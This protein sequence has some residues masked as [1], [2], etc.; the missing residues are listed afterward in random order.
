MYLSAG[1]SFEWFESSLK[2]AVEAGVK[3]NGFM[4]GRALWSDA[5]EIF[6]NGGESELRSWLQDVGLTRLERLVKAVS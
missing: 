6:G 5:V 2:L 1:V 3:F 4:C